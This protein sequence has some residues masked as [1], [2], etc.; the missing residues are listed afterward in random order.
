MEVIMRIL[1]FSITAWMIAQSMKV[2]SLMLFKREFKPSLFFSSGGM[3]SA[4]S[5]FMAS[6]SAQIGLISGFSSDVFA[7]SCAI[8][9]VVVYD[10]Y[11]VRRSVGLQGK[12]LN[13][14]IEYAKEDHDRPEIQ[15]LKEVMGHTPLQV[16]CGVLLGI[17]YI[18]FLNTLGL[19]A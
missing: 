2:I 19:I 16:F 8:T 1:F 10:A 7:L 5:A 11:N 13:K 17:V 14:M 9:T 18:I 3:P 6:V 12:A 4:H 15:T